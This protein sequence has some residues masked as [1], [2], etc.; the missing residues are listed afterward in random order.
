MGIRKSNLL[1][2]CWQ[3]AKYEHIHRTCII[4]LCIHCSPGRW[5]GHVEVRELLRIEYLLRYSYRHCSGFRHVLYLRM[6][7]AVTHFSV[8]IADIVSIFCQISLALLMLHRRTIIKL[9]IS[10]KILYNYYIVWIYF[11]FTYFIHFDR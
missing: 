7:V 4:W 10:C 5:F 9:T 1:V 2:Y 6:C 8:A 3:W 11:A